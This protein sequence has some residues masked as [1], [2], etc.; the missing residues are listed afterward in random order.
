MKVMPSQPFLDHP[1]GVRRGHSATKAGRDPEPTD[2][3]EWSAEARA[4]SASDR[5]ADSPA[6]RARVLMAEYEQLGQRRFGLVVSM[7]ARGQDPLT[8]IPEPTPA[9]PDTGGG[10]ATP[11]AEEVIGSDGTSP[12]PEADAPTADAP[13]PETVAADGESSQ[14]DGMDPV[15]EEMVV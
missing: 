6:H 3:V 2:R 7:L 9:P 10:A 4:L 11:P 5:H 15:E 8:G 14:S 1:V 12:A 13:A